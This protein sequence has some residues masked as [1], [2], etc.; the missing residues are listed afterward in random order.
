MKRAK[1][2][3]GSKSIVVNDTQMSEQSLRLCPLAGLFNSSACTSC[4]AGTYSTILGI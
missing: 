1:R 2:F 4:P 3:E